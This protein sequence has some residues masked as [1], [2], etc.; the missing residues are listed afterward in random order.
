MHFRKMDNWLKIGIVLLVFDVILVVFVVFDFYL[1]DGKKLTYQ[2]A[3]SH[4]TCLLYLRIRRSFHIKYHG[5]GRRRKKILLRQATIC[6][7]RVRKFQTITRT[8]SVAGSRL[9]TVL[10]LYCPN[11][12]LQR[13]A[14]GPMRDEF[15]AVPYYI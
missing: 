8:R 9:L 15:T 11:S 13:K 1:S 7:Q 6:R 4:G 12:K 10:F 5:N 14:L 3:L 2:H